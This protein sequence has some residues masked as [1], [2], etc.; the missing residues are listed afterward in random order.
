MKAHLHHV[1]FQQL[2]EA[3][4]VAASQA[5]VMLHKPATERRLDKLNDTLATI[6]HLLEDA[7]VKY[8][9]AELAKAGRLSVAA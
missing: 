1:D 6:V 3:L 2:A 9:E 5:W 8:W 7:E 4:D